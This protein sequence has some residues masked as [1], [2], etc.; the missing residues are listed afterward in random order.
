MLS[1]PVIQNFLPQRE[2]DSRL[3][4]RNMPGLLTHLN[5]AGQDADDFIIQQALNTD[6]R[7]ALRPDHFF[8]EKLPVDT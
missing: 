6:A 8:L 1:L 2:L 7:Y 5:A 4:E 3:V